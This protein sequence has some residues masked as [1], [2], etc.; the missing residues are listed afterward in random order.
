MATKDER[1]VVKAAMRRYKLIIEDYADHPKKRWVGKDY[2]IEHA[3]HKA[4]KRLASTR[5]SKGRR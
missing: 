1:A 4:C 2:S 3:L 5:A